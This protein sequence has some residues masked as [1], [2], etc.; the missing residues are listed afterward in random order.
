[1]G[2][3]LPAIKQAVLEAEGRGITRYRIAKETGVSQAALSRL[4]SGERGVS[5]ETAERLAGFLGLTIRI[6][7]TQSK[8]R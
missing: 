1:M 4:M 8:E 2:Q 5:V 3:L 7:R 6:E